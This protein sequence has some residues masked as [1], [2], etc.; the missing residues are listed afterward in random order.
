M[1]TPEHLS[2]SASMIHHHRIEID[3]TTP[4]EFPQ[5]TMTPAR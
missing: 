2:D 5:P 3:T 1:L 4:V